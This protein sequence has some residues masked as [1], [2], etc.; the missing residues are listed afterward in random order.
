MAGRNPPLIQQQVV[1]FDCQTTGMNP[2]NGGLLELGWAY[3]N[4]E[5]KPEVHSVVLCQPE[6]RRIPRRIQ[7]ITGISEK[8]AILGEPLERAWAKLLTSVPKTALWVIHYS[9]FEWAFVGS[10]FGKSPPEVLC[11]YELARRLLPGLGSHTI[12]AVCGHLG[13]PLANLKRA[14][15]H[16]EATAFVWGKMLKLLQEQEN[17]T[18]LQ[19]F[20]AWFEK[21]PPLKNGT[22][23]RTRTYLVESDTR[24]QLSESPGT[25]H[26]KDCNG[27]V[28]YVGKATS[29]K[30]RV[31]SYFRGKQTKGCR[32]NEMLAQVA[33]IKVHPV[34]TP[35]EAAL[36]ENDQIKEIDPPYNRALKAESRQVFYCGRDFSV[37]DGKDLRYGP[38]STSAWWTHWVV[39]LEASEKP[40]ILAA[41]LSSESEATA[42]P[43]VVLDGVRILEENARFPFRRT[44]ES[45]RYWL[46]RGYTE[47]IALLKQRR[48][49]AKALLNEEA[50][51]EEETTEKVPEWD[52]ARVARRLSKSCGH[53]AFRVHSGRWARRFS[54]CVLTYREPKAEFYRELRFKDGIL[55]SAKN[56]K[57]PGRSRLPHPAPVSD[58]S[59]VTLD[60]LRVLR[61]E[62]LRV[63]TGGGDAVLQSAGQAPLGADKL[64]QYVFPGQFD[65]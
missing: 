52:A 3:G 22:K 2:T 46:S 49:E 44:A 58:V 24:L 55:V 29:L 14:G 61:T 31:N 9:K 8:D 36:L 17:V 35:L 64:K 25:Y 6:G 42:D 13:Q 50:E 16:V 38:F 41:L 5:Q 34:A 7:E 62:V 53:T 11:T 15:D 28:L 39:M 27:N 60:R 45:I 57:S 32:L 21:T 18:T 59:L 1:F 43:E 23:K 10:L 65:G 12:R 33:D 20:K 63:L 4:G 40:D 19:E 30:S 56:K 26:L 48:L 47:R 51:E 37:T 54:D